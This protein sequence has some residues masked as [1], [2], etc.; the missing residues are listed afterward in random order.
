MPEYDRDPPTTHDAS[1]TS[2]PKRDPFAAMTDVG[3]DHN[4]PKQEMPPA[5]KF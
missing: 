4:S 1:T 3:G 2:H 5:K